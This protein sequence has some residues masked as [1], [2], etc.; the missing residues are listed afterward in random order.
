MITAFA[1]REGK[2]ERT[3]DNLRE[4][5]WIDLLQPSPDEIDRVTR[6]TGVAIPTEA[7]ISEIESSSRLATRD[8]VLYLSMPLVSQPETEPRAV[9]VGFVLSPKNFLTVRFAP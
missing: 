4:A 3:T 8:G 9:S 6:E 7:E 5:N 1:C 2:F